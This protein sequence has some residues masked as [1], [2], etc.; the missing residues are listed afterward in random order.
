M[1]SH[2]HSGDILIV[3]DRL[4][5]LRLLSNMLTQQ[6][7]KV[8]GVPNGPMALKVADSAPPDLILLDINMPDMS[9][10]EVCEK[11]KADEK[12]S[13]IPIVFISALDEA[14]DKVK[15]FSVGGIDYITKPFQIEEVLVR[16]ETHLSLRN[17]Q[18][19]LQASNENLERR[20]KERTAELAD[21][22]ARLEDQITQRQKEEV[23]RVELETQLHQ[24]QK[25]EALGLM[26]GGVAHD[27]NNVLAVILGYSDILEGLDCD[28]KT[29]NRILEI[30]LAA[31]RG[32]ALTSQLLAFS[33]RQ[34][35]RPRVLDLN[36]SVSNMEK[37]IDRL[38]GKDVRLS[39]LLAPDLEKVKADPGQMDQVVMNLAVNAR[40]AMPDGGE[41]SL[42]TF[43]CEVSESESTEDWAAGSYV[44]LKVSDTGTGIDE[45]TQRRIFE[46]FFTTKEQGK[47]TG[48][49]L[50]TVHGIVKQSH[51]HLEVESAIGKG[52]TFS[53]HLPVVDGTIEEDRESRLITG[54]LQGSERVLVV[55]NEPEFRE[56]V[57]QLLQGSGYAVLEAEGG[58]MA[59]Q[60]CQE[61]K[62]P[63]HLLLTD[64]V[65]PGMSGP[66]LSEA[67]Q[68]VNSEIKVLY[69]SGFMANAIVDRGLSITEMAFLQKP[70]TRDELA[71][72]VREV[73]DDET[74]LPNGDELPERNADS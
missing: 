67:L 40:D 26:A 43:N 21:T 7:Y 15:A 44:V 71:Y 70:F 56:M 60:L 52:T 74:S 17:L 64:V 33:R 34:V 30:K 4:A 41:L 6:G 14:L 19:V 36:D 1:E 39:L 53:V 66:E 35:F 50:A 22:V 8:R 47:G 69:M 3:D 61:S 23:R 13:D 55:E 29:R 11:L 63:I 73:L 27:F 54:D 16:V 31:N 10:Y 9:G 68:R 25:M 32:A 59:L 28:E 72:K 57:K 62:E 2:N 51:G 65:M 18:K 46:P 58:E 24:S 38:V 48:L 37:M 49:G 12:T 42:V 45:E 5:N 20:V